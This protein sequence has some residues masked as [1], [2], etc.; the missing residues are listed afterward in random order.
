MPDS[1]DSR[2]ASGQPMADARVE[3]GPPQFGSSAIALI[4]GII[5]GI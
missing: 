1:V 4:V 5:V 3:H 2:P